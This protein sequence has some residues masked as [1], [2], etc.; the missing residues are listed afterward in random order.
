[1]GSAACADKGGAAG[2]PITPQPAVPRV[3]S[4]DAGFNRAA[5][6]RGGLP[7]EDG[8]EA[9]GNWQQRASR[10]PLTQLGSAVTTHNAP[11]W[12]EAAE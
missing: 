7:E 12:E 11:E 4:D 1:M 9:L 8:V 5:G 10:P 2:F 6:K 3:P